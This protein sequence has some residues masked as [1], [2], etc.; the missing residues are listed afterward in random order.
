MSIAAPR[1]RGRSGT[2]LVATASWSAAAPCRF[3]EYCGIRKPD[4]RF[5]RLPQI[6]KSAIM[7]PTL[8]GSGAAALLDAGAMACA[9][10]RPRTKNSVKPFW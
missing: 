2:Q 10:L 8:L 5:M 4:P 6:Q 7:P 9:F 1:P 3:R